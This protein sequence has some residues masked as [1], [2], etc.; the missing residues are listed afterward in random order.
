MKARTQERVDIRIL[1]LAALTAKDW[2]EIWGLTQT[3]VETRRPFHEA[4]LRPATTVT[5][6]PGL[7]HITLITSPDG[8]RAL[9][10]LLGS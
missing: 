8:G 3:Y 4:K 1:P 5:L 10:R 6:V 9:A 2:D 7:G